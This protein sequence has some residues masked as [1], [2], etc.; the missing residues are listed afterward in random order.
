MTKNG[1]KDTI[2][3]KLKIEK[4]LTTDLPCIIEI[5][6]ICFSS[7]WKL[8]YFET[9][10]EYRDSTCLTIRYDKK[11]IGYVILRT[12]VDETH[13]M[14]IAIHPDHRENGIATKALEYV[15]KN[16]SKEN[17]ML[18]EVRSSNIAA[19]NLYKKMGFRSLYTRK[20]YYD[21]GEDAIVMVKGYNGN[22]QEGKK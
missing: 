22:I 13:I 14:N 19:Q 21:D 1:K 2:C 15:F 5:E 6:N 11:I 9:E 17:F 16:I 3:G 7:P 12:F 20:S 18:L 10:M 4:M 8:S